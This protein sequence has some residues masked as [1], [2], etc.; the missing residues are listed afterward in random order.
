MRIAMSTEASPTPAKSADVA[1]GGDR[2]PTLVIGVLALVAGVVSIVVPVVASVATGIF[3]GLILI[4][5]SLLLGAAA[6]SA[7]SSGGA[8]ALRVVLAG[9]ML[10]A[11]VY[12]LVAPLSGAAALTFVLGL[13][14]LLVGAARL[15]LAWRSRGEPEAAA[16]GLN[17][18]LS[19][20]IGVLI[21]VSLPSSAAWAIGLLVGI[22]FLFFG[23]SMI[24]L[25]RRPR[26]TALSGTT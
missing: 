6:F 17:G 4:M 23:A 22:D 16:V 15:G 14:F 13:N 19:L 1:G 3:I 9:L 2:K 24:A 21:L 18:F 20:I 11:G 10:I 5:G 8:L 26:D 12:L 7:R 25:A